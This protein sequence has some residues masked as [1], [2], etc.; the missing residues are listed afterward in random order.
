M[1]IVDGSIQ[2]R[3]RR[4]HPDFLF[5]GCWCHIVS[6]KTVITSRG[7]HPKD[8][9]FRHAPTCNYHL[10]SISLWHTSKKRFL[11]GPAWPI[12]QLPILIF[13]HLSDICSFPKFH[14]ALSIMIQH[15]PIF[16]GLK[17]LHKAQGARTI[18]DE[19]DVA[20]WPE[21]LLQFVEYG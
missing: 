2:F 6:F 15:R 20:G 10:H 12:P 18:G 9:S 5:F 8:N 11:R 1:K 4:A 19:P 17:D 7:L 21:S 16:G 14:K 3:K 13:S